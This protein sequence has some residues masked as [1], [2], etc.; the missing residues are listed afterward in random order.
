MARRTDSE[1]E[2]RVFDQPENCV[3]KCFRISRRK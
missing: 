1:A 2:F 3:S